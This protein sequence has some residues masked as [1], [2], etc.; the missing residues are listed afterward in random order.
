[1]TT[2]HA[3]DFPDPP[4]PAITA[5]SIVRIRRDAAARARAQ[6]DGNPPPT[7]PL[8]DALRL[9]QGTTDHAEVQA[10]LDHTGLSVAKLNRLRTANTWW[11]PAGVQTMLEDAEVLSPSVMAT[12]AATLNEQRRGRSPVRIEGSR[13]IDDVQNVHIRLGSDDRW[14]P[15]TGSTSENAFPVRGESRDPSTAFT[16]AVQAKHSR[17]G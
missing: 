4:T 15:F 3:A 16:T 1:M 11:G 13:I 14:Y 10:I 7:N 8:I 9:I 12:A 6:L 2:S 5:A 17:Q